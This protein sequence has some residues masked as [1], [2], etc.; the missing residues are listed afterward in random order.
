MSAYSFPAGF[1]TDSDVTA[2]AQL[3]HG[4]SVGDWVRMDGTDYVVA[5]ADTGANAE[6]VGVIS[7][8]EDVDNFTITTGGLVTGL[9]G[10]T[11]G[12]IH[13]LDDAVAGAIIDS[14]TAAVSKP[15]LIA[16]DTTSGYVL[17]GLGGG[18]NG[19]LQQITI[20]GN[21]AG[22]LAGI[23]TGTMTLAG[24]NNITLS[25]AGNAITISGANVGGAQTGISGVANSQTT[26]T[27]GTVSLSELGAITIRSTTGNQYQF[28]VNAQSGTQF[29]AG[30]SGGNTS[31]D[32][33]TVGGRVVLAGGNGIT[34]SGSTNG[35][36]ETI[37]ISGITQSVQTQSLFS[38]GVSNVGNTAGDT[39]VTGTRMVFVGSNNITLSQATAAAGGTI[40]ISGPTTAAQTNQAG[41]VYAVGN[42]YSSSSGTYDARTVSLRGDGIIS[43]AATNSGF[44]I[45]A[46]QSVQPETQ[47]FVGGIS[48]SD[49]VYT[50]GTVKFS[51]VGGG[52]TV[53]S[54]TGQ[55]V[56]LS[57]A[58]PVA[59]T[60]QSLGMYAVQNTTGQSS[61]TTMDART[62]SV[63]GDG[64]VSVGY[65]GGS[66]RISAVESN[67]TLGMYAVGNTTGQSSST[68][69]DARSLSVDG[70]GAVSVGYSGGTLR[71]SAPVQTAQ[72]GI[73][74]V[75]NSQTTYTSGT[76]S[77][78]ELGAITIRSTTGNQ[79]Q[80]SVNS[81]TEQTQSRF[82]LTMSGNT[83]GA[84]ALISSGVMTLAGGNAITLSQAGN[85]ITI[86]GVAGSFSGG[87]SNIG[88]TSGDTGITGSRL[89]LAGGNNITLSQSTNA[90]GGT[91]TISAFTQTVDTLGLYA[92]GNTT[93]QSSSTTRDARSISVEG[94][95]II[96]VG[97]SGGSLRISATQSVQPETQTF[98]GGISASDTLYTSGSVRFTG[99]GGGVTVSSNTG[100][101]VDISVAAP[102]AQTVQSL[103]MYAV[104]NTTGQSSSTTM[105]ARTLSVAGD[106][107]VSV[108]YSGGSLRISAPVQT[109]QTQNLHNVTISGNTSGALAAISSG[110]MTLAGGA[111]ITLSQAGNAV[112]ISGAAGGAFS[113]GMSTEGNTAGATG[114][115]GSRMVLVGSGPI[116]LSQTTGA[117]GNT[118][119]ILGPA[120]SSLV[121][122]A[123]IT[124]STDGSTISIIGGAGAGF[125]GGVSNVG[126]TAGDTGI[127][128]SRLVLAG[129]GAVSLSQSTNASGGTVSISAP[130]QTAQTGISSIA[131]SDTTYTSG[132][133]QFTGSNM[134]TVKSSA[135][136]RVVIDATQSVQPVIN[137][138]ASNTTFASGTISISGFGDVT[139]NT[140]ANIIRISAPT[141]TV[142][143]GVQHLV[144]SDN[145]F[146]SGTVSISGFGDITVNTAGSLIR[147]S[148]PVQT[149]E[150]HSIGASNMGNTLGTSGV[151][152][153]GQVRGII[154]G[155]SNITVSQSV[156]GASATLSLIGNP[157]VSAGVSNIGN[158]G[159]DTGMTATRFVFVGS[160]NVTL[161]Q[162]T[163]AAGATIGINAG[164][165]GGGSF[166]AGVSTGGNTAGA[167][168]ISGT[169]MVL[170]GS[171]PIS[172]SQT[173]GANG[174][175]VSI[176]GP[177]ASVLSAVSPLS[178][179]TNGSTIS[180]LGPATS[181]LVGV[182]PISISTNGSTISIDFYDS[183]ADWQNFPRMQ[184]SLLSHVSGFSKTP[185]YW[186]DH[187]DGDV[188]AKS[189][190]FA[191]SMVTASQPLSV[192]VHLGVYTL[193]NSTS[194]NLLGSHSEAYVISS[195]TSVSLSGA[196]NVIMTGI[197]THGTL[198][199]ITG[200]EY[201]LGMMFSGT[202]TQVMNFSLMG[203]TG[204]P[205]PL[206]GLYPGTNNFSAGTSQG[207]QALRGRGS[208]TV[209]AMPA[210][211]Q[212]SE[213]VNQGSG[214]SAALHP[215]LYIRS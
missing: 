155:T 89:V 167:T 183:K 110:T 172:L 39:G 73:S 168:G 214:A 15:V 193:V 55:R 138:V 176:L 14:D 120:T 169:Q 124:V 27:S 69:R 139:V 141:Q 180:F 10:L 41:S 42:T 118:V 199:S 119:S 31:G 24:G 190:A 143:P 165:A 11:A 70:A 112:T 187:I 96:S 77:L 206:G 202:A 125:S 59:Q 93:G 174:N 85:A 71:I 44:R 94:A 201:V 192:S 4:L 1:S 203:A 108:G 132:Q 57:V 205:A 122:G 49:T 131:A 107:A 60:N 136:Q 204:G 29:S 6:V 163:G 186:Q 72:T 92:L 88:N 25:Q 134:I 102:V 153:G 150:S 181:S 140:A 105:D 195:A 154:V 109:V 188:L 82:N 200:G 79:Y 7:A 149:V 32:T 144:A 115:S 68:T 17:N 197:G 67:Q 208:T 104:Q 19:D 146:S 156:N 34:L 179:S 211:V 164:A 66:L 113:A 175:T 47:T 166:S 38:A 173:T 16:R 98:I 30:I 63:A 91:V 22:A 37:T 116:S 127:T 56:D 157:P 75:A 48:A 40:T 159:G 142:Q 184:A 196:R 170:V 52:I 84:G 78:S 123:N 21:T 81:Q 64:I 87:M 130:V 178:T 100:Q 194:A 62:L 171:S 8:V 101:R 50:S 207:I 13:Y 147:I 54:N 137:L 152:S 185:I 9:S 209:N 12:E 36:S 114:V 28:S 53:S 35:A 126:N 210:A 2:V 151:A 61:S 86:S 90:S 103:G 215:W 182:R 145:T 95:G 160:N 97:Y 121:A 43:I 128:G 20:S 3:A 51:G 111:N 161:S 177:A 83:S 191:I 33:G 162:S 117:A 18:G 58:A 26:Y 46:S 80:F 148:G 65:S 23:S 198:S 74:G 135:N 106:G 158:T 99:V 76:V 212:A 133:V 5:Q 45:S 189:L 129:A 213:L